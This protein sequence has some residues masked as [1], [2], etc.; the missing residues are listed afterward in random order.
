ML[1]S[2]IQALKLKEET[3]SGWTLRG[4]TA[5]E[6]VADHSWGT[7]YL[8]LLYAAEAQVDRARAVEMA[9]V[10]DLAEAITGDVAT[11]VVAMSDADVIQ[12][13]QQ[14]ENAAM[15][16]LLGME[17]AATAS[18]L[19]RL[20]QEYEARATPVAQFVR[21]MNMIDMCAQALVYEDG[22]R[23]DPELENHNFPDFNGLDEFFATTRPR[24]ATPVGRRLFD[25]L[26]SRYSAIEQVRKRGGL[27]LKPEGE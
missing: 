27:H 25:E 5:P 6:S 22:G 20:W 26:S 11:R 15:D 4:V 17:P 13:K 16:E 21:D 14:R 7:A 9:V 1:D 3:R 18:E 19:R 10:H 8:C 23:Y 12:A 24:L 2:F